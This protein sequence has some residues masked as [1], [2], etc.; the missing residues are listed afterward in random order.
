VIEASAA[1]PARAKPR[2]ARTGRRTELTDA[3]IETIV[4]RLRV[5]TQAAA[6]APERPAPGGSPTST[7]A[8]LKDAVQ[9]HEQVSLDYVDENARMSTRLVTP[10]RIEG[11][12]L[13]GYDTAA[14]EVR[15]YAVHRIMAVSIAFSE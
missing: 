2:A 8:V 12:F 15:R 3:D 11:G 5:G 14:R 10:S 13:H 6:A 9:S 7:L 1:Q 4:H